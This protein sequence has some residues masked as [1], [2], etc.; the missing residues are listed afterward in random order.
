MARRHRKNP[1][2]PNHEAPVKALLDQLRESGKLTADS[3]YVAESERGDFTDRTIILNMRTVP[4][5]Y[6]IP[7]DEVVFSKWVRNLITHNRPMPWDDVI[8]TASTYLPIAR[9][10][11]HKQFLV[12]SNLDWLLMLDSDVCP[13]PAFDSRL[14]KRVRDNP[15]IKMIGGW[16]RKKSEPYPPAVYHDTG[17]VTDEGI[18]QV[19]GYQES[20]IGT[21]VEEVGAAGAG[22]WLMHRSVAEAVG[23]EPYDMNTGGEDMVLCRKL[24]KLGIPLHVDW[25]VNCAHLG[26]FHI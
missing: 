22:C 5:C 20:E 19:Q 25:D 21:D 8:V 2:K 17:E 6:G 26:V 12:E 11:V 7:F 4:V 24:M 14:L 13:P 18:I 3:I 15:E 23:Q 1:R 16:Y 9:N 10:I